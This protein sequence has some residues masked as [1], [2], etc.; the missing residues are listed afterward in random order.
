VAK[1]LRCR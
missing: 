1:V